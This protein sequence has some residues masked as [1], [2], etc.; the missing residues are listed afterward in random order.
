MFNLEP[1]LPYVY[2]IAGR[3]TPLVLKSK[4][5]IMHLLDGIHAVFEYFLSDSQRGE[6]PHYT[7]GENLP[8][9]LRG[10]GT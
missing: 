7:E 6:D 1:S 4:L 9:T 8:P 3:L 2:Q 5:K 10:F